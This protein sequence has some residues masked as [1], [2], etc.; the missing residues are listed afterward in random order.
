MSE[1]FEE[2]IMEE[3]YIE[4]DPR[5]ALLIVD[6]SSE[7]MKEVTFN[8]QAVLENCRQLALSEFFH[9]CIDCRKKAFK[10]NKP[11]QLVSQLAG[12]DHIVHI[13]KEKDSA[14]NSTE[15]LQK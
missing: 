3:E 7:W 13:P 4:D 9:V 11:G 1:F 6:M 12:F 2:E 14:F 10:Y 8:T 5:P 15:V